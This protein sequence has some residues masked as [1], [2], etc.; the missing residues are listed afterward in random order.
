MLG[1]GIEKAD[2]LANSAAEE[3][4]SHCGTLTFGEIS[5][6]AK[7]KMSK[8]SKTPSPTT[9]GILLGNREDLSNLDRDSIR[10]L[11]LAS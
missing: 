3:D 8:L 2:S 11:F 6:L 4:V 1:E 7:I 10:L 9:L 5:S